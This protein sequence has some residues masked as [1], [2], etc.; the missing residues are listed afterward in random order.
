MKPRKDVQTVRYNH[1]ALEVN[2]V[3]TPLTPSFVL[4]NTVFVVHKKVEY[5]HFY[6]K[7]NFLNL[8]FSES[9]FSFSFALVILK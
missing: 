5:Y 2:P 9:A 4:L 8:V 7:I 3:R 6:V 1:Q